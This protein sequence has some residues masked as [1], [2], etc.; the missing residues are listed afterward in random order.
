MKPV[1][2]LPVDTPAAGTR[3]V[4]TRPHA[5]DT[6]AAAPVP[7][8]TVDVTVVLP[9]LNE[10]ESVAECVHEAAEA[11]AA[12][13]WTGEVVVADNGST[14]GSRAAARAAGARVVDEPVRGY[15]AALRRGFAEAR[16]D[17]L[18]MADADLTYPL[19][20]LARIVEPVRDGE[21]DLMVGS[22]LDAA[23][24][25]SM[26]FL[27]RF[28]GT[29]I[30][31]WMVREGT[32]STGLTDSQSGFRAFRRADL[33]TLG[34]R[35]TGM[36]L[37]SEMLIRAQQRGMRIDEIPLGYRDRVGD[38]KLSTWRD[39]WRHIKLIL[40]LSPHLFLYKPGLASFVLGLVTYLLGFL[41]PEG[42][43]IGSLTWNPVY[44]GTILVVLGLLGA[45]AG[46]LLARN[47]PSAS[48]ATRR[49][50]AWI[51]RPGVTRVG[52]IAGVA[53]AVAGL[54]LEVVLF[55]M[56]RADSAVSAAIRLHLAALAQGLLLAG[57]I[58]AVVLGVYR[59]VVDEHRGGPV[60]IGVDPPR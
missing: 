29:P 2:T 58:L 55:W 33:D 46:A 51:D 35:T 45:L 53:A 25:R 3:P 42:T 7:T 15:G 11:I 56:W 40:R 38:S 13:G 28:V 22:R 18:V 39:G 23:T 60:P 1:D 24:R 19:N 12:A 47:A 10:A 32:G 26:P 9:C 17:V 30:L 8:D 16:G 20:D 6:T 48:L 57:T 34:M 49:R 50:F 14:D 43:G 41:R 37:A 52:I 27:H 21:V 5:G 59:I 44:L 31:T 54:V 36:E 4:G